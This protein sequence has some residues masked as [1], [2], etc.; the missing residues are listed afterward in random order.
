M[1][2]LCCNTRGLE[3]ASLR[4]CSG[5]PAPLRVPNRGLEAGPTPVRKV[6]HLVRQGSDR[7]TSLEETAYLR[8]CRAPLR[9]PSVGPAHPPA[10][11]TSARGSCF[12]R[13]FGFQST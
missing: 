5:A 9:F 1:Q 2:P 7:G 8:G 11:K 4:L 12:R 10:P 13:H 6:V 3:A